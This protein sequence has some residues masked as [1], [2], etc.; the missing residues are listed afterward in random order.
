MRAGVNWKIVKSILDCAV[1]RGIARQDMSDITH[2]GIDEIS[3]RRGYKY[4]TLIYNLLKERV[5]WLGKDR[6]KDTLPEIFDFMG[7]K[8]TWSGNY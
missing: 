6:T 8:R 3:M 7:K 1:K 2:I 4:F 5:I